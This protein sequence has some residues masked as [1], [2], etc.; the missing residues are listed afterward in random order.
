MTKKMELKSQK[1]M[2]QSPLKIPTHVHIYIYI[3]TRLSIW[4]DNTKHAELA[5][6]GPLYSWKRYKRLWITGTVLVTTEWGKNSLNPVSIRWPRWHSK[7]F[8][9]LIFV[10]ANDQLHVF[11]REGPLAQHCYVLTQFLHLFIT[12]FTTGPV[13]NRLFSASQ[14]FKRKKKLLTN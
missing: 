5:I 14:N 9:V 2:L 4:C 10:G 8:C 11:V 6:S 1:R 12:K 7:H 13:M 3:Y